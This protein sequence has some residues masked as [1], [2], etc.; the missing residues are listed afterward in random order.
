M[1]DKGLFGKTNSMQ[2]KN[3]NVN[4]NNPSTQILP[5]KTTIEKFFKLLQFI[6]SPVY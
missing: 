4:N 3:S 6:L 1:M 5:V 2:K